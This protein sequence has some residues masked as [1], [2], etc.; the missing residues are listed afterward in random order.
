MNKLSVSKFGTGSVR[1]TPDQ[2]G[3]RVTPESALVVD[4]LNYIEQVEKLKTKPAFAVP[5]DFFIANQHNLKGL[6]ELEFNI[7]DVGGD[8]WLRVPRLHEIAPPQPEEALG[9]WFSLPRTPDKRPELK[10]Q[11]EIHKGKRLLR[12]ERIEERP[13]VSELFNWYVENQWQPWASAEKPRREVIKRYNEMFALQ[14]TIATE[15]SETQ[16]ELVW[17]MG[18]AVWKKEDSGHRL[19]HPLLTQSCEITLNEKNFALEVRPREIDPRIEL[20]TY[21]AM[22]LPGI[23]QLELFW[24][25]ALEN[26]ASRPNPFEAST[27]EGVLKAAVG[28]LDPTGAYVVLTDDPTPPAPSNKLKITNTWVLFGRHRSSGVFLEDLA[29]LK[30]SVE[31]T[32]MLPAVV[33]EF[34]ERGIDEITEPVLQIFRGL[35]SS[36]G[37]GAAFELYFPMAYNDEQVSIVQKLKHGNGVVVQGPPGTGKTHTI[38]NIIS[39]YLAQGLRVLVTS[40]GESALNEVIGKLPERIRPLCVGLLSNE[41]DGMKRFEHSIQTIAS[42]VSGMNTSRAN[43]EI[44]ALQER[45]NQLHAKV[46]NVDRQVSEYASLHMRNYAFQGREVTPEEM[47]RLV[48]AQVDEHQW[49]DDD[50]PEGDVAIPFTEADV[51]ATRQARTKVCQDLVYL[52]TSVPP[53][54]GFPG[55]TVL[56]ELH[57]DVSR[58]KVIE[59]DIA[60]GFVMPLKDSTFET[61]ESAKSLLAFIDSREALQKKL[62]KWNRPGFETTMQRF[63]DMQAEDP[64][65]AA[66]LQT[67][68]DV[69][70][71]EKR[72]KDL[73]TKAVSMPPDAE[74][75]EHFLEAVTRQCAGKSAFP[76]PFGKGEARKML[77]T[78]SVLGSAPSSAADWGSVQKD[79]SVAGRREENCR[80]VEFG[81]SGIGHGTAGWLA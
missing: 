15:G 13:E 45:L 17:G 64:L 46:S 34:V 65:L 63:R 50:L 1:P 67:C 61:F 75:N 80:Q 8:I 35:S 19:K 31:A 22:E 51:N 37:H 4:L 59:A 74:T 9:Q 41:S 12:I 56:S 77:A 2:L 47:A 53:V 18:Y 40:R 78:V 42:N 71:L 33:R 57:R 21:T 54:D 38:A 25:S 23:R 52:N 48:L 79:T 58:S 70:D 72:R 27:F 3:V 5:T 69:W 7:Q 28:H 32:A 49:M 26:G 60:L 6:P 55:W 16:I 44:V 43:A 20:D 29:R 30:K 11:I 81:H 24:K 39:H 76:V 73:L 10:R 36:E 68:S 14:Q 66:L 62:A